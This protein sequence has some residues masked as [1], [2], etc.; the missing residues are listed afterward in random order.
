[1]AEKWKDRKLSRLERLAA[2]I[3]A[4]KDQDLQA[5]E[6][7]RRV[8]ALRVRAAVEL[9]AVC[10]RFARDLNARLSE[11]SVTLDP[12]AYAERNYNDQGLSLFQLALRGRLLQI[13][14]EAT[15][16][17]S[18]TEDFRRPYIM[19]GTV[20][21]FNQRLLDRHTVYEHGLYYCPKGSEAHW[22]YFDGRTYRTGRL[23]EDFL[24]R[25]LEKLL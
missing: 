13:E 25:E 14:F 1:M 24:A 11:A 4:V 18:S 12:P 6:E 15:E 3:E 9:H 22:H 2:S 16:E 7:S 8:A 5:I 21:S 20:R 10:S 19:K 17:L 23:T